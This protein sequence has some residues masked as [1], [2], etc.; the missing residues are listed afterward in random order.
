MDI[1]LIQAIYVKNVIL[2]ACF[3]I[4][5]DIVSIVLQLC[6]LI[7]IIHVAFVYTL[8]F[9]ANL[10]LIAIN[11]LLVIIYLRLEY[12]RIVQ[13]VVFLAIAPPV[14]NHAMSGII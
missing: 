13:E 10:Q 5:L 12:V 8:V 2:N 14:V 4:I 7:L 1:E 11:V 6:M 3:V 9:L